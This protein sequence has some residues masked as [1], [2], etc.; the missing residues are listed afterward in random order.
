MLQI[1]WRNLDRFKLFRYSIFYRNKIQKNLNI[2]GFAIKVT[3]YMKR[4]CNISLFHQMIIYSMFTN[5]SEM[6]IMRDN[7]TLSVPV[8][9]FL[10]CK[11]V[12]ST[13]TIVNH[14]GWVRRFRI[15]LP[16]TLICGKKQNLW[17]LNTSL[18]SVAKWL[19]IL[20]RSCFKN[21]WPFYLKALLHCI[22]YHI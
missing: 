5:A 12:S 4:Y 1:V 17:K 22:Q 11:Y 8:I 7:S 14:I 6:P 18:E 21:M 2:N 20:F 10:S 19:K 15:V 16:L 9:Q 3:N 13:H